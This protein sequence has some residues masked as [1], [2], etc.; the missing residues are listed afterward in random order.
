MKTVED[1]N[2]SGIHIQLPMIH[3]CKFTLAN[4]NHRINKLKRKKENKYNVK[5]EKVLIFA[6]R[7]T[8]NKTFLVLEA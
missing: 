6:V 1:K 8:E 4:S 3:L 5:K 7:S 2:C